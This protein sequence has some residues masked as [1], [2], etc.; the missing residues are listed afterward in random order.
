MEKPLM[1]EESAKA[2][3]K[4]VGVIDSAPN[5]PNNRVCDELVR[6]TAFKTHR[7]ALSPADELEHL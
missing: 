7:S 2:G 5:T 4:A 3:A 6:I 1:S